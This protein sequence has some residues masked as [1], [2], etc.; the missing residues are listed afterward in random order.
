LHIVYGFLVTADGRRNVN[1]YVC[2][3]WVFLLVLLLLGACL[4]SSFIKASI[5]TYHPRQ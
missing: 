2:C 5:L 1:V 4:G 3:I